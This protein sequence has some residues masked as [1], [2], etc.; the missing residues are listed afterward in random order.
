MR[1]EPNLYFHLCISSIEQ[2]KL[3]PHSEL[4]DDNHQ[5]FDKQ[6]DYPNKY[7]KSFGKLYN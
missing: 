7:I 4:N 2:V 6:H 3:F 5:G 1:M